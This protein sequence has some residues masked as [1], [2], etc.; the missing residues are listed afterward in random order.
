MS[1]KLQALTLPLMRLFCKPGVL[2]WRSMGHTACAE[3]HFLKVERL[4]CTEVRLSV[5]QQCVQQKGKEAVEF[6]LQ[7]ACHYFQLTRPF[8]QPRHLILLERSSYRAHALLLL[9]PREEQTAAEKTS[10]SPGRMKTG[11]DTTERVGVA[12]CHPRNVTLSLHQ[13]K[14]SLDWGEGLLLGSLSH[15]GLGG[16]L[17][18]AENKILHVQCG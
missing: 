17:G 7:V 15:R 8:R 2:P 16:F 11:W 1:W 13:G 6:Y 9:E 3:G 4:V 12:S 14:G 18:K 10:Q 5:T